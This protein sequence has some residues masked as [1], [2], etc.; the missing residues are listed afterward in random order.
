MT[1]DFTEAVE[2]AEIPEEKRA[3]VAEPIGAPIVSWPRLSVLGLVCCRHLHRAPDICS[4]G[5]AGT[6]SC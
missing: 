6:H 5:Y 4:V 3:A 1:Q 2:S